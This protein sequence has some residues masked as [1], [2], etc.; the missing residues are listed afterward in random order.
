MLIYIDT[1]SPEA[2]FSTIIIYITTASRRLNVMKVTMRIV[3][4]ICLAC[5]ALCAAETRAAEPKPRHSPD[6]LPG[7]EPEMLSPDYWID[8]KSVV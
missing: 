5:Y 1:A 3:T 6:N 4:M 8:R 2:Y 7:V